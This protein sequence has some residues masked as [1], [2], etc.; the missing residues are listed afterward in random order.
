MQQPQMQQQLPQQP[1]SSAQPILPAQSSISSEALGTQSSIA[2]LLTPANS[3]QNSLLNLLTATSTTTG[4]PLALN[5]NSNDGS[6]TAT[7]S[8]SAFDL[9]R[10]FE[11]QMDPVNQPIM[12]TTTPLSLNNDLLNSVELQAVTGTDVSSSVDTAGNSDVTAQNPN[13]LASAPPARPIIMAPPIS[14]QTF[15]SPDLAGNPVPVNATKQNG[16]L[17][18]ILEI[19]KNVLLYALN[20]LRSVRPY[21][22]AQTQVLAL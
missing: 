15:T 19:F 5:L 12:T 4:E 6:R 20:Y 11:N 18:Q 1:Q 10:Q 3:S 21:G 2:N 22:S 13:T 17:I 7:S 9:I 16:A 14:Q 8:L